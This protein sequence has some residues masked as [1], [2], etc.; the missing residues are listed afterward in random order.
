MPDRQT[1][2]R[3]KDSITFRLG[4]KRRYVLTAVLGGA[5]LLAAMLNVI[6]VSGWLV[7]A[8]AG[9]AVVLN[10]CLTALATGA[11]SSVWWM[12]YAIAALDVVMISSIVAVLR[13]DVLIILYFLVIVPYS[14]DRGKALGYFT[15]GASA[16]AFLLVRVSTMPGNATKDA[17]GWCIVSAFLLLVVSSQIVP[18]TSRLI[19]RIR[20]TREVIEE[21]EEGNLLARADERYSDELGLLQRSFNRMLEATGQLIA[22]VQHEADEV[23]GLAEQLATATGSL[24]TNGIEFAATTVS[25]TTQLESQHRFASEGAQHSQHALSTSERLQE[26]AEEMES[27]ARALVDTAEASRD[28]IARTATTLVTISD[29]VR[30]T[31]VTV[32]ALGTAS[33]RVDEFVETVSRIARQTNLLALN[34]AIEAARAGEH[35][36][37]FAVVAEEVRKLAEESG[38]AAKEVAETISIVHE[39][40][41]ITINS[42]GQGEREVRDVGTV[43]DEANLAL[44]S[45]L[46]GIRRIADVVADTAAV[47]RAQSETMETL[48][49][50]MTGVQQVAVDASTRANVASLAAARQMAS[51]DGLSTTSRQLAALADRLRHSISRF[52]VTAS[53]TESSSAAVDDTGPA[54]QT[55]QVGP[56]GDAAFAVR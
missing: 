1:E 11:L 49:A 28:A 50:T 45:M 32:A 4:A 27:D 30:S 37:G 54:H 17:D 26:H 40:I 14:F 19:Y 48:T 51:L 38:R 23:A 5:A 42:M 35:G 25:L 6:P 16:L 33:E 15:A 24:S 29:R 43:T 36:K 52:S 20:R 7:V 8:I 9:S 55:I 47:S 13:R 3:A 46:D 34:A 41:D 53:R 2:D 12:R 10:F 39:N 22:T 21:A 31:A 18:I 44:G 56:S